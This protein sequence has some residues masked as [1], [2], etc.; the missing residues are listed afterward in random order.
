M[1]RSY[2]IVQLAKE[3]LENSIG[4]LALASA[5][6][7]SKLSLSPERN[8]LHLIDQATEWVVDAI[9]R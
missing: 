3:T 7:N 4:N 2:Q 1:P 8:Q 9:E 6:K 5:V